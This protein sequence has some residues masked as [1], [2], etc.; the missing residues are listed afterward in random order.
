MQI[1]YVFPHPIAVV[2]LDTNNDKLLKSIDD[3]SATITEDSASEYWDCKLITSFENKEINEVFVRDNEELISLVQQKVHE[4]MLTVGWDDE[5]NVSKVTQCWFNRYSENHHFQEL[6]HHGKHE[7]CAIYY[8]SHSLRPTQFLNPNNYTFQLQYPNYSET[9]VTK[10]YF[11]IF[12]TVGTL[13]IFP[14]YMNHRIPYLEDSRVRNSQYDI[15][16]TPRTTV[17]FNFGKYETPVL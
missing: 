2:E 3:L 10:S 12:P 8:A 5:S 4:Y 9:P 6:H 16:E 7:V 17:A 11:K 14:G 1:D 15:K 13:V